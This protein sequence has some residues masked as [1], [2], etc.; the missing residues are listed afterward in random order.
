[1]RESQ[2]RSFSRYWS[3]RATT[4]VIFFRLRK[5]VNA[6]ESAWNSGVLNSM[7]RNMRYRSASLSPLR[8][9]YSV[10]PIAYRYDIQE[11]A[12]MYMGSSLVM[13]L[14]IIVLA[15]RQRL[16]VY[17]VRPNPC[18]PCRDLERGW[19]PLYICA[20]IDLEL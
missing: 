19:R 13:R 14:V 17:P 11:R 7:S 1:M 18:K 15:F 20:N 16:G 4:S 3:L 9:G 10:M 2:M 8:W 5:S 6:A 12:S